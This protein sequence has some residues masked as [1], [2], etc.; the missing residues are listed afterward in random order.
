MH[1][2]AKDYNGTEIRWNGTDTFTVYYKGT[3]VDTFNSEGPVSMAQ[4][5]VLCN[6][7]MA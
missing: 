6:R 5:T 3:V 7:Y 1:T 4:A 2:L